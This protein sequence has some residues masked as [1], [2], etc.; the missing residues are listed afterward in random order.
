VI[1]I[2]NDELTEKIEKKNRIAKVEHILNSIKSEEEKKIFSDWMQKVP[3]NYFVYFTEK[4][5]EE[6]QY[7]VFEEENEEQP[8]ASNSYYFIECKNGILQD[9]IKFLNEEFQ[10]D[11]KNILFINDINSYKVADNLSDVYEE[12]ICIRYC[13]LHI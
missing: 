9:D 10:E 5:R 6:I 4:A 13:I 12:E 11:K 2:I 3:Y 1:R 7:R 8:Q